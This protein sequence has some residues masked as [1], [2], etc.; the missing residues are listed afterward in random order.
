MHGTALSHKQC[1]KCTWERISIKYINQF[2]VTCVTGRVRVVAA[3]S[4]QLEETP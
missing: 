3:A 1:S 2:L 4:T